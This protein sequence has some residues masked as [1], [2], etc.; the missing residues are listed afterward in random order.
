MLKLSQNMNL[1]L[2]FSVWSRK[3]KK[4]AHSRNNYF[5]NCSNQYF[6]KSSI[7]HRKC[8]EHFNV[9]RKISDLPQEL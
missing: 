9:C 1:N 5:A 8:Y 3:H 6:I 2:K 7:F 4:K